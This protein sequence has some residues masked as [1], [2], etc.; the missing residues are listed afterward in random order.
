M[1]AASQFFIN[2]G[3]NIFTLWSFLWRIKMDIDYFGELL[4]EEDMEMVVLLCGALD[5]GVDGLLSGA[6]DGGVDDLLCGALDSGV[7]G[8]F[9]GAL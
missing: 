9:Y 6:L 4:M 3:V 7:Y 5:G 2:V 1:S 8:L